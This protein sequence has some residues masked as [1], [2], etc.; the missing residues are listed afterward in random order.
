MKCSP[1][2]R[3][4][5]RRKCLLTARM[6]S[7]C[8]GNPFLVDELIVSFNF[9]EPTRQTGRITKIST[10]ELKGPFMTSESCGARFEELLSISIEFPDELVSYLTRALCD[11]SP[12]HLE[13]N[14]D[15]CI[16]CFHA[17]EPSCAK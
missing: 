16:T 7:Y 3:P 11:S 1:D 5:L 2:S 14:A 6:C 8:I 10:G 15:I 4:F 12:R 9:T 13:S 17:L